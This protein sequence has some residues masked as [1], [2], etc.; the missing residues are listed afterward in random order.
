[1]ASRCSLSAIFTA[2]SELDCALEEATTQKERDELVFEYVKKLDA[3]EDL[4]IP[5][6]QTG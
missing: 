1:M 2:Q 4:K 6:F 3:R 5:D